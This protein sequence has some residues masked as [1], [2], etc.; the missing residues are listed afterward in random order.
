[1][2]CWYIYIY[3]YTH[4]Y[5]H[6]HQ[7][8]LYIQ[9][10]STMSTQKINGRNC[11]RSREGASR[12]TNTELV[13]AAGLATQNLQS[14]TAAVLTSHGAQPQKIAPNK[15]GKKGSRS[16][17][18]R[19][20]CLGSGYWYLPKIEDAAT[21]WQEETKLIGYDL[22][23]PKVFDFWWPVSHQSLFLAQLHWTSWSFLCP[24]QGQSW[25]RRGLLPARTC[26]SQPQPGR[27]TDQ[28]DDT[29]YIYIYIY[30]YM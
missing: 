14:H 10:Y 6:Q 19:W 4:I 2:T 9:P 21:K 30:I 5:I 25:L 24:D 3:E 8:A 23:V 29:I 26:R 7:T 20:R 27:P 1:M 11:P 12:T 16:L 22:E 15:N 28:N 18:W 17:P 13:Q